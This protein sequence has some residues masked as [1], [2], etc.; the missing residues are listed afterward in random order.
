MFD[1]IQTRIRKFGTKR[2]NT[3]I[4]LNTKNKWLLFLASYI[5]DNRN[6]YILLIKLKK[7]SIVSI[8]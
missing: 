3:K 8:I 1:S 5:E 7:I 2:V 4:E 6:K